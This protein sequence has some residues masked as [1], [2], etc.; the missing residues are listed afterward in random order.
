LI[1]AGAPLTLT[2]FLLPLRR[3]VSEYLTVHA[4]FQKKT[5][6]T[7]SSAPAPFLNAGMKASS[8][9]RSV[10]VG[11]AGNNTNNS[12]NFFNNRSRPPLVKILG[13]ALRLYTDFARHAIHGINGSFQT[14]S[15]SPELTAAFAE[16]EQQQQPKPA[17]VGT[18]QSG[19][20][21]A[22][23]VPLA[24]GLHAPAS[25]TLDT[26]VF[27]ALSAPGSVFATPLREP[28]RREVLRDVYELFDA[29][30][31]SM[32]SDAVRTAHA[33]TSASTTGGANRRVSIGLGGSNVTPFKQHV[34]FS[35]SQSTAPVATG[36]V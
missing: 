36:E 3:L 27:E 21:I 28:F 14:F 34:P 9:A 6:A 5:S 19:A 25:S 13:S 35:G 32:N 10:A 17:A 22:L 2:H 11:G 4:A 24:H 16:L 29:M 8:M 7:T 12:N 15:I 23:S 33:P 18:S 26:K 30:E 1:A 20:P 31:T